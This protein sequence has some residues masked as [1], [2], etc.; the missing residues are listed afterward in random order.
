MLINSQF[1]SVGEGVWYAENRK[2]EAINKNVSILFSPPRCS[3]FFPYA[4]NQQNSFVNT[5]AN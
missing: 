2:S 1:L 5:T 4:V 3:L